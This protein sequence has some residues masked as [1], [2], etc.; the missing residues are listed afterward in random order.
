MVHH[1]EIHTERFQAGRRTYFLDVKVT[2][3]G[4]RYLKVTEKRKE[5]GK[6]TR[7]SVF[8]YEEDMPRFLDAVEAISDHFDL[9]RGRGAH[10]PEEDDAY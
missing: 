9:E 4:E 7:F 8:V 2:G 1:D 5:D 3:G 10:P 6:V